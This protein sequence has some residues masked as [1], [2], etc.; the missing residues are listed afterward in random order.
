MTGNVIIVGAPRSGT[1]MLRNILTQLPGFATWP[2]DEINL[3]WKHGNRRFPSD[4]LRA[5]HAAP[6]VTAYLRKEFAKIGAAYRAHTVVEKTCATSLRVEFVAR[7]FPDARYIFIHR[8]GRDA[9]P[10]AMKR[11]NA[12]FDLAYTARKARYVPSTDVPYYA[13]RFLDGVI[14]RRRQKGAPVEGRVT[15]WWGPRPDDAQQLMA[16]HSLDELSVIQWQRCV[17]ATIRG[18]G[19]VDPSRVLDVEYERFVGDPSNQLQRILD[20]LGHSEFTHDADLSGISA[21]SV[22]KGRASLDTEA[23]SRMEELARPTL[24]RLGYA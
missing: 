3:I 1:N 17:E 5:E 16:K 9:A 20:F 7:A 14:E 11:W 21:A 23:A 13:R 10:S 22:G 19:A 12:P 2:C 15:N 24:E 8:D 4:E 18:L 6:A